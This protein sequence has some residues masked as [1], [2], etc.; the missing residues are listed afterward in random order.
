MGVSGGERLEQAL[1]ADIVIIAVNDD[2][3]ENVI[4]DIAQLGIK[5]EF[6]LLHTAGS[7]GLEVLKKGSSRIGILYPLQTLSKGRKVN[8]RKVPMLINAICD[9]DMAA[10]G[11]FAGSISDT[12]SVISDE[13]REI[14]HLAAVMVNNFVNHLLYQANDF[15][16]QQNISYKLLESLIEET[17]KKSFEISPELAQTGPARRNDK[18]TIRKHQKLLK[19]HSDLSHLYNL[20]TELILKKYSK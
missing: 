2:N 17:V 13:D 20:F 11:T 10:I 16:I 1:N 7:V 3:I 18:K 15:L 4:E 9:D 8:M 6:L 5:N 12:V 14:I 19:N